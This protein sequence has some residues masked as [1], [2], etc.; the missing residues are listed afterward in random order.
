MPE[1]RRLITTKK[2]S[3]EAITSAYPLTTIVQAFAL[4]HKWTQEGRPHTKTPEGELV[5]SMLWALRT[6]WVNILS[7]T[8]ERREVVGEFLASVV[9]EATT[10]L[11]N[12]QDEEDLE[13]YRKAFK[14]I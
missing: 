14:G 6:S 11:R 5:Y 4:W 2:P 8:Y 12:M 13:N 10:Q 3:D 1:R 9:N 7:S